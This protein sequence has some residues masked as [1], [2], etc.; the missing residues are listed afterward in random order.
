M[1]EKVKMCTTPAG[2]QINCDWEYLDVALKELAACLEECQE[3]HVVFRCGT[4]VR[5]SDDDEEFKGFKASTYQFPARSEAHTKTIK[6]IMRDNA[7][8]WSVQ[9]KIKGAAGGAVRRAFA[10]L[11]KQGY[12][13]P[14]PGAARSVQRAREGS[15]LHFVYWPELDSR[16]RVFNLGYGDDP[17]DS[18]SLAGDLRRQDYLFP[19]VAAVILCED[20]EL[21]IWHYVE[22]NFGRA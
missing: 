5:V 15:P 13:W 7:G 8:V 20:G 4:V 10:T 3:P 11:V 16:G 1:D 2:S 14:G 12:P 9:K 17:R 6:R 18:A 21:A 22:G 19:E